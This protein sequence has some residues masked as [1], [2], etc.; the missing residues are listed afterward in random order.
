MLEIL[1]RPLVFFRRSA[2]GKC[3][4]VAPL[5][6]AGIFLAGIEAKFAGFQFADHGILLFGKTAKEKGCNWRAS[7]IKS[8]FP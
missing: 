6:G 5:S 4:E 8:H 3:A 1:N 2:A 7:A